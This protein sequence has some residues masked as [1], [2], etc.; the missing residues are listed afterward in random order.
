MISKYWRK[1]GLIILIIV[2]LFNVTNKIVHKI[3]LKKQL[4]ASAEYI[5]EQ[6]TNK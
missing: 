4:E 3:S 5:Q 6:K 1:L 2:C